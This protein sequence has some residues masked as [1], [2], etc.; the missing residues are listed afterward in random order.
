LVVRNPDHLFRTIENRNSDQSPPSRHLIEAGAGR[1]VD[2]P[3]ADV[4][5]K[6]PVYDLTAIDNGK[7]N[8]K[9]LRE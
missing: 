2:Q 5:T 3:F 8:P 9:V 6:G 1:S 7:G 4:V